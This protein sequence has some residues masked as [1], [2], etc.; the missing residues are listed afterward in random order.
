MTL[1]KA[2]VAKITTQYRQS[3]EW[4]LERMINDK[5]EEDAKVILDHIM[6]TDVEPEDVRP[7]A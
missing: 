2:M 1:S 7:E 6:L 5:A 3:L 4:K